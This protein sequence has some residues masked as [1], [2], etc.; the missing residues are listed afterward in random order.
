MR[1]KLKTIPRLAH[2]LRLTPQIKLAIDI[3][4]LPLAQLKEYISGQIEENPLLEREE[5]PI[6]GTNLPREDYNLENIAASPAGLYDHLLKQL[7][8]RASCRKE[9]IAGELIISRI[10]HNG[11]FRGDLEEIAKDARM[12]TGQAEKALALIQTFDPPGTGA[13]DLRECLLIQLQAKNT[14]NALAIAIADKYLSFLG[15]KRYGY[16][17]GRLKVSVRDIREEAKKISRLE[18]KPGRSFGQAKAAAIIPDAF[19]KGSAEGY[20]IIFNSRDLPRLKIN[21]RYLTILTQSNHSPQNKEYLRDKLLGA[22][23]LIY[24]ITRRKETLRRI[25]QEMV[26]LQRDFLE[27]GPSYL[28]PLSLSELAQKLGRHKST[29]SRAIA[30]KYILGPCGTL[31]LKDFLSRGLKQENRTSHSCGAV[32]AKIRKL[33]EREKRKKPLTDRE[34]S[35]LLNQNGLIIHRRTVAKYRDQ[36]KILPSGWR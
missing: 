3:L 2:R 7:R 25:I 10:D 36:M 12:K 27:K 18:P 24:G 13:R 6:S 19:L 34:I 33:I 22:R 1:F 4:Q 29:I 5:Y 14:G 21:D 26:C 35:G 15:R 20:E 28:R 8:F 11:Y 23:A 32:K 17:A 31:A 30:G 9:Y 16:I